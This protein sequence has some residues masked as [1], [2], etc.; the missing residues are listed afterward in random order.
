[1]GHNSCHCIL[2]ISYNQRE[3]REFQMYTDE[4]LTELD[5]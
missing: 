4:I 2:S 5:T 1:M 3:G